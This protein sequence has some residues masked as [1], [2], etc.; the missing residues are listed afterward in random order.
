MA[1][2]VRLGLFGLGVSL[3]LDQ[4]RPLISDAQFTWGER[5]VMGA[6]A[7]ITLGGFGLAGWVAGR[8]VRALADLI[9]V[10]ADGAEAAWRTSELVELRL[11]PALGR[12]AETLDRVQPPDRDQEKA[13]LISAVRRALADHQFGQA[14]RLVQAFARDYPG[15]SEAS[16]LVGE[17]AEGR[18]AIVD[19]LRAQLDAA[20]ASG[21]AHGVIDLRD[22]LTQHLR[23]DPLKDLDRRVVRWLVGLIQ[24]RISTGTA[25]VEVAELA[26]RIADSFGDTPEGASLLASLPSLRRD[27]GLC[28]RCARP[29]EGPADA[30]PRCLSNGARSAPGPSRGVPNPK[31]LP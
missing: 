16:M 25:R 29:Y 14:E 8:L 10:F 6:V 15:S 30:C 1:P 9:E 26:A 11:I 4:V 12:I 18:Q 23:G 19:D 13:R 31:E 17:L 20:R 27:A 24:K 28:P 3:F 7:L 5:R 2:L 21:D 22:A